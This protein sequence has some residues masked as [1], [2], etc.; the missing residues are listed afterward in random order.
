VSEPPATD[1][2]TLSRLAGRPDLD[3]ESAA[4]LLATHWGVTGQLSPLPSERDQNWQVTPDGAP[5][6]VLKIANRDEDP[7]VI[8]L[9]QDLMARA[10]SASLP[11]P[12]VVAT[13]DGRRCVVADGRRLW[14]IERLPGVTL[15]AA[16][17]PSAHL[18][19]DLG[20]VLGR[21]TVALA[22]FDH[23]AAHRRLQWDAQHGAAVLD[24]YRDAV[25]DPERRRLL[26][27]CRA[28]FEQHVR[29]ALATL[30]RA[31]IHNDAN[32]HNV[33]VTGERVSGLIDFG[34][35]VHTIRVNEVAVACA[36]AMFGW[37]EPWVAAEAVIGGYEREVDLDPTER[38]LLPDLIRNR[39]ATSVSISAHQHAQNPR[40]D[41]LRVSEDSAWHLL[42]HLTRDEA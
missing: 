19:A 20:H 33:L 10:T 13:P 35:A 21:L 9:Q 15:A 2:A 24:A 25:T 34:D 6:L 14:L 11:V 17:A 12:A 31:V 26:D 22:G 4:R 36:Y 32:D 5:E 28:R 37:S 29:P 16:P 39:L 23:P 30:P 27:R 18:L 40:D 38:A 7:A 8:D 3:A 1:R 42:E 41:Y